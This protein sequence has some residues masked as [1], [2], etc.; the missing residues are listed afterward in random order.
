MAARPLPV[1]TR[2]ARVDIGGNLRTWRKL[3]GL[4]GQQ[5]SERAAITHRPSRDLSAATPQW[6]LTSS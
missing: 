6:A 1:Q 3:L 2:R 5:V 4:T